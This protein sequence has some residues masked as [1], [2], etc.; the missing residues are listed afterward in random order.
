M[1]NAVEHACEK[2][3]VPVRYSSSVPYVLHLFAS[4]DYGVRLLQSMDLVGVGGAALPAAEWRYLRPLGIP[5]PLEFEPGGD[6]QSELAMRSKWPLLAAINRD[7]GSYARPDLLEPHPTTP[8]A[9]H[10]QSRADAH[11]A[12]VNGKKLSTSLMEGAILASTSVLLD[13]TVFVPV[14]V[15]MELSSLPL[16]NA[17][18]TGT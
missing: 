11:I 5:D 14:R 17:T 9:W 8:T 18:R 6:G 13:A 4:E 12:L 16:R 1:A 7:D 15:S 2:G 3:S 10:G